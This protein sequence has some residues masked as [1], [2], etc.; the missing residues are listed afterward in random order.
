MKKRVQHL[1]SVIVITG[2]LFIAYG[3]GDDKANETTSNVS[4]SSDETV[5]EN[6]KPEVE[7]LKHTANYESTMNA[8][9]VH[10]RVK[11]N[12]DELIDYL[13]LKATFY[14]KKGDIVGTGIGNAANLA[15]GAEKTIDVL[16]I[17][18]QNAE[19]YEVEVGNVLK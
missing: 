15:A 13:D 18:I 3:S 7:I 10:C 8:Y 4:I 16:G 2:F 5:I 6:E 9:T 12:T 1:L 14:N 19:N 17:D 11:N